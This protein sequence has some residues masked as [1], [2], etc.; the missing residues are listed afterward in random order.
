MLDLGGSAGTWL[1]HGQPVKKIVSI[2]IDD[3]EKELPS[4]FDIE[5]RKGDACHLEFENDSFDI[6]YSNSVIEHVGDFEQQVLFAQEARRVGRQLWIQT[7]ALECPLEPHYLAPFVHWLPV[8]VRRK[9]LRW[10]T[11]WGWIAK[12][13]QAQI[14]DSIKFTQLLSRKQFEELFPDC[15][16]YTEKLMGIFPK[17]YTAYRR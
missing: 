13:D 15:E 4:E 9:I 12:P 11:P 17:S 2:N 8:A 5:F 6:V 7:P 14:D 16:I 3:Q 1:S 10:L